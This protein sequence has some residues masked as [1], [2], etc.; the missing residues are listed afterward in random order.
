M[1]RIFKQSGNNGTMKLIVVNKVQFAL[2][3]GVPVVIGLLE[4]VK[5]TYPSKAFDMAC[6]SRCLIPWGAAAFLLHIIVFLHADGILVM[7]ADR[8]L[9]PGGYWVLSSPPIHWKT[10]YKAWQHPK[11][12]LQEEQRKIEVGWWCSNERQFLCRA[13]VLGVSSPGILSLIFS[14]MITKLCRRARVL[15]NLTD[16]WELMSQLRRGLENV[17]MVRLTQDELARHMKAQTE[18]AQTNKKFAEF[19][20]ALEETYHSMSTTHANLR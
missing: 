14:S 16:N 8:V 15:D 13:R 20:S 19:V 3:R 18:Q 2:E 1:N 6:C 11:E 4:T 9:W 12:D 5:M 7:E 10:N 17:G